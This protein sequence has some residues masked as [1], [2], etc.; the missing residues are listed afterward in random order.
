MAL[1]PE[2]LPAFF[3]FFSSL[4]RNML[5]FAR[6]PTRLRWNFSGTFRFHWFHSAIIVR[7]FSSAA[8]LIWHT[9]AAPTPS[10]SPISSR[11]SSST[12]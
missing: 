11:F 5:I 7:I 4:H 12:K 9:R 10:V 2:P 1:M 6:K 8:F 3:P